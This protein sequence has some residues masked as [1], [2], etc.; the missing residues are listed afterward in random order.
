MRTALLIILIATQSP[1]AFAKCGTV[2]F[3]VSGTVVQSDKTPAA[4]ALVGAAWKE[5][6]LVGGPALTTSDSEGRYSIPITFHTYSSRPE[7]DWYECKGQLKEI[8]LS[9]YSSTR[10]APAIVVQIPSNSTTVEANTLEL[11]FE[12]STGVPVEPGG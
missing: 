6:G 7:G 9:A 1:L 10:Y 5:D 12:I 2:K 11:S 3:L 8:N 4:G